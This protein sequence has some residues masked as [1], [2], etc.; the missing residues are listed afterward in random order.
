MALDENTGKQISLT[1]AQG[2]VS[3]FQRKYPD[4][5]KAFFVGTNKV[6]SILVQED[7]IGIRIYNGYDIKEERMNQVLIGVDT[8]ENDMK[9][10]VILDDLAVCP[11]YCPINSLLD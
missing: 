7:C 11:P 10:G 1:E 4:E 6:N 5:A 9:D 2:Y 3:E 8:H